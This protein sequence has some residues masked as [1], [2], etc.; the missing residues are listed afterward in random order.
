VGPAAE[1]PTLTFELTPSGNAELDYW[2]KLALSSPVDELIAQGIEF[3]RIRLASYQKDD[4]LWSGIGRM[5]KE[6][7]DNPARQVN[8]FVVLALLSSIEGAAR[9]DS[10]SLREFVPALRKRREELRQKR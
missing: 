9:P 5:T 10:P 7:V 3:T 8:E 2:R 4:I 6:V 1:P